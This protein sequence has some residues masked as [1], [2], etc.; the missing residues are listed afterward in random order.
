MKT[1]IIIVLLGIIAA[2]TLIFTSSIFT[3][4]NDKTTTG[5][6]S[7]ETTTEELG[8]LAD[9]NSS[10]DYA[11]I[12]ASKEEFESMDS[13]E[14]LEKVLPI[15]SSYSGKN[16]TTFVF[17]DGT[18]LYFA[19]S[20]STK[21]GIYGEI[22]EDGRITAAIGTVT[23]SG[24]EVTYTE[25]STS[26]SKESASIYEYVPDEYVSDAL[27]ACVNDGILYLSFAANVN[28]DEEAQTASLDFYNKIISNGYDNSNLSFVYIS[29]NDL[30]GI[31]LNPTTLDVTVDE[32]AVDK[33]DQSLNF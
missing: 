19:F 32:S 22:D 3:N 29:V 8:E 4:K 6:T 30:Y 20:D 26:T 12:D 31:A 33:V 25:V 9:E 5:I 18:G 14:F 13:H 7:I 27:Y 10:R 24:T 15:L 23:I 11:L 1:K 21:G 28:S 17:N 16:Y 2:G